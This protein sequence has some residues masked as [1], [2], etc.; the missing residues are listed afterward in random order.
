MRS[1]VV[2]VRPSSAKE[3][4]QLTTMMIFDP[5]QTLIKFKPSPTNQIFDGH[6]RT[7]M[8]RILLSTHDKLAGTLEKLLSNSKVYIKLRFWIFQVICTEG[9]ILVLENEIT[10]PI[11]LL[12]PVPGKSSLDHLRIMIFINWDSP[13]RT[14]LTQN[15]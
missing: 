10:I 11:K 7:D 13:Y 9:F 3:F 14:V 2:F 8:L 12:T 4:I 6:G 5:T 15:C 1:L